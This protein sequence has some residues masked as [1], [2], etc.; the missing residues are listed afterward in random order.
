MQIASRFVATKECDASPAY[1]Q[2]Y[3]NA[4]QED[5]QIIQSPVGMPGRALRNAF[6]EQLD[7]SRIPIS[8]CYNC[9]EKCN[10]SKSHIV[11]QKLL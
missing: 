10:P 4:R 5:V 7:N 11:L 2:A 8:K 6:I 3:I 1:K 9:L